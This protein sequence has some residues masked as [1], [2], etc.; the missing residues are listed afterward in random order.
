MFVHP[1]SSVIRAISR[2]INACMLYAA[3]AKP[4]VRELCFTDESPYLLD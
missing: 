4:D 3:Y 2:F 1:G